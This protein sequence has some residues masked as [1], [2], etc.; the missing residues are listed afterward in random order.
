[1]ED[2]GTIGPGSVPLANRPSPR[3]LMGL[4]PK[5]SRPRTKNRPR[6]SRATLRSGAQA[7]LTQDAS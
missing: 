1:M 7:P 2:V 5:A 3:A 4:G 6:N